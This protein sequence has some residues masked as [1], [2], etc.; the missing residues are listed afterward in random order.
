MDSSHIFALE[1]NLEKK[2]KEIKMYKG[3]SGLTKNQLD[4]LNNM[5]KEYESKLI[6]IKLNTRLLLWEITGMYVS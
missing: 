3:F 5:E 1:K 2:I 6:S 4:R